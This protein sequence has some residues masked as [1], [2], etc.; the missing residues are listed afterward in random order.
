MIKFICLGTLKY[1]QN[2]QVPQKSSWKYR[3]VMVPSKKSNKNKK[4]YFISCRGWLRTIWSETQEMMGNLRDKQIA[5]YIWIRITFGQH[6]MHIKYVENW[7]ILHV[8]NMKSNCQCSVW[9]PPDV[10]KTDFALR[11]HQRSQV[12]QQAD[13]RNNFLVTRC[14]SMLSADA[15]CCS[16]HVYMWD[17][18]DDRYITHPREKMTRVSY[19]LM[20]M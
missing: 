3:Q 5:Q 19:I 6:F 20:K 18:P 11:L 8:I 17:K 15:S 4:R 16:W 2:L 12:H 13:L 14:R 10:A 7:L 9:L 1:E